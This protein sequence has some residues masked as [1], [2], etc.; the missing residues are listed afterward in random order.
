MSIDTMTSMDEKVP[1]FGHAISEAFEPYL[2]IWVEAQ[3][4]C[5][6]Q[7]NRFAPLTVPGNLRP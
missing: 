5:G 1:P 7:S 2:S 3:D 4:R 6:W